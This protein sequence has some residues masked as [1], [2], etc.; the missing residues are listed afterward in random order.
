MFF[1][2]LTFLFQSYDIGHRTLL[3]STTILAA[4]EVSNEVMVVVYVIYTIIM[5]A[6]YFGED[7][8]ST[9]C[10]VVCLAF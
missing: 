4:I 9:V 7:G 8:T 6:F 5:T 3:F 10:S 2:S 1:N